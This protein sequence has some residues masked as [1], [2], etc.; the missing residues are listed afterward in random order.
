MRTML[1][2]QIDSPADLRR[3][4]EAELAQLAMELRQVIVDT[5]ETNGGHLGSNLGDVELT[6]ALHRVF[7]SPNDIILWDTGHQSY[8]HKLV[9]GRAK[10]FSTIRKPGGLSGYPDR[11]ESPHDWIENSHAST[12]LSYA[13]GLATAQHLRGDPK[14]RII[15]VIGDGSMT[16]GMAYEG[17][18]NLG[19]SGR[20]VIIV[21]NDNGRSYAPTVSR[22]GESLSRLRSNPI[23]RRQQE[24]MERLLSDLP[25]VGGY[26]ERGVE[27]AKAAVREILEP[28]AFF[29]N[30]G[31]NY[32]GPY[33]GHDIPSVERALT[34]AVGDD[35]TGRRPC[36]D[37]QGAG[38]RPGGE[39]SRQE[40]ARPLRAEARA[41]TPPPSATRSCRSG[42]KRPELV[43]ITAAMPDSTGLSAVR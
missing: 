42:R 30:L 40:H 13:H 5:I 17:L 16:G 9:T 32:I 21:L 38:L 35:R 25:M 27:G 2:D 26:I 14:K 1:L 43:A 3:L 7:D 23:Y 19:H 15:A 11:A 41:P 24:R 12:V 29:E 8:V 10:E 33:D 37:Q 4:D 6:L 34:N 22:L 31:V 18:N 28:P 39:R 36:A 20:N